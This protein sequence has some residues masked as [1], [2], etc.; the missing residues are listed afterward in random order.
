MRLHWA[1]VFILLPVVCSQLSIM[2]GMPVEEWRKLPQNE[3]A[4][5]SVKELSGGLLI[6]V[7]IDL[8][9]FCILKFLGIL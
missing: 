7:I 8:C 3:R 5:Q 1:W 6:G 4:L 2:F 9:L